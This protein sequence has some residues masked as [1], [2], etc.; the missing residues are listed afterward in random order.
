MPEIK[1]IDYLNVN[2]E[3]IYININPFIYDNLDYVK[4]L[5]EYLTTQN[6]KYLGTRGEQANT[7]SGFLTSYYLYLHSLT[8][9]SFLS[10]RLE[11]KVYKVFKKLV[12]I[13][14]QL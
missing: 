5:Y 8:F 2:D 14:F 6:F 12:A 13:N 10:Q 11:K 4:I 9:S 7:L 1:N 3:D